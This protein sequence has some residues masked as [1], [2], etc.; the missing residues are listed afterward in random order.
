MIE[1]RKFY[2]A[3]KIVAQHKVCHMEISNCSLRE[4]E[5]RS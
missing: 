2:K 4:I 1:T 3:K 5:D